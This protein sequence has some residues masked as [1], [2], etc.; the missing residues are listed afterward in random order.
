MALP[1]RAL[2]TFHLRM[3][4][5]RVRIKLMGSLSEQR[6]LIEEIHSSMPDFP[7]TPIKW[8]RPFIVKRGRCNLQ[9]AVSK[10]HRLFHDARFF[11]F[12]LIGPFIGILLAHGISW[13]M[14]SLSEKRPSHLHGIAVEP[15]AELLDALWSSVE[16]LPHME[17]VQAAMGT[18]FHPTP[19]HPCV[20]GYLM[21]WRS[22]L[23]GVPI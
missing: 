12:L 11:V 14:G 5:L 23:L 18:I 17:L 9:P 19:P 22:H 21:Q 7:V 16:W 2:R 10:L 3:P 1:S 6:P 20:F 13:L 8:E 15:V 4:N